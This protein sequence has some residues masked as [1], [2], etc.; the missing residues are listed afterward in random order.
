M[1]AADG[2][3]LPWLSIA[4]VSATALAY[5][6][7]LMRL[8]S[9]IQWHHFAYMMI[10]LA[11]LG[12]GVSGAFLLLLQGQLLR[13]FATSY[14]TNLALF[15]V[16][17]V[18]CFLLAQQIPFNAEEVLWDPRQPVWLLCTYLLLAVP[19]FFA[20]N[21]IGLALIYYRERLSRIYAADLLGAGFGSI[22]ILVLLFVVLPLQA[23][24]VL[25]LAGITAALL[26]VLELRK[27][28]TA[29]WLLVLLAVALLLL[30]PR[31]MTLEMSPYKGLNETLRVKDTRMV[32]QRSSPLG[33]LSVVE[34]PTIPLRHAPGLSLNA[35]TEPPPQLGVFTDGDGLSVIN[36]YQGDLQTLAYLDQ[37]TS[38]LPYHLR[39]VKRGLILG[40]GGG[41]DVL[42][43]LYHHTSSVDAVELNPQFARLVSSD[44]ADYAGHLYQT[45]GVTLHLGEARSFV[46]GSSGDY[47]LIQV[48]LLD[49]FSASASGQYA[50]S[51]NHL[52]TTE[53]LGEFLG[54]LSA[55]GFLSITRWIK[56]PPRD[57]LKLFATAIDA[58]RASGVTDPGQQL[59]LI[60]GWQTSTLL[61]K[62]G[63]IT[64][65]ELQQLRSFCAARSFDLAWYPGIRPGESNH[66]NRLRE[67]WFRDGAVALLGEQR[68]RFLEDYKFNLNPSTDDQPYFFHFF[69]WRTLL[70]VLQLRERG[71][72]ALTD[73]GYLVLVATLVQAVIASLLLIL[74]PIWIHQRRSRSVQQTVR[75]S[76][77]VGYFLLLGLSFLFIEI[78]FIQKFLLFLHHPLYAIA[79]VL[80]SFLVFSGLGSA[81][82][83]RVSPEARGKRLLQAVSA[84]VLLGTV[85]LLSLDG[86]LGHLTDL[87][88]L[89]RILI[90][91]SLIAPLA[92][93]MGMP[94]PLGLARLAD[95]APDLIPWAWAINGCASVISAVLATLL[96]IHLGF[97]TVIA[98]ALALYALT[99]WVF[100][101]PC[102]P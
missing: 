88:E 33:L 28:G 18:G 51:E 97:A 1:T 20:A 86:L 41:T 35:T 9:I 37:M 3:R 44:Y 67:D 22:A 74:L 56:L 39:P 6:V 55:G 26:G 64:A 68:E 66:Y 23:L 16:S 8:F 75:G 89:A 48:S 47:D 12:Y 40:A 31:W 99:L 84:I 96:A 50:L 93:C 83:G 59:I 92:F 91:A 17:S 73:A 98:V 94:F 4:L 81:W 52:Y 54:K 32:A 36:R 80:S 87:P 25:G 43:A 29:A 46:T 95:H 34:S 78:A 53:A 10:S 101:T 13:R 60:R 90:S 70:E 85:Y 63:S 27:A 21:A 14:L 42:Q 62:N 58:L 57:T 100:P 49:S 61:V 19:F 72:A 45:A 69:K 76:M 77:V 7:L 82:S 79:V 65:Q 2:Q 71:G 30:P 102:R 5:E 11:L 38:A 15:G 24:T